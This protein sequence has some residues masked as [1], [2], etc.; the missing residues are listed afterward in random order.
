MKYYVANG[1]TLCYAED[2]WTLL[3]VLRS[4]E[5]RGG[6]GPMNGT[7]GRPLFVRDLR[8]A[9]IADF[10]RFHVSPDTLVAALVAA[11]RVED[12]RAADANATRDRKMSAFLDKTFGQSEI[13]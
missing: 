12:Q 1:N 5:T 13:D 11:Y 6:P 4:D 10:E 8:P 7:I 9:T 3:G 2:H